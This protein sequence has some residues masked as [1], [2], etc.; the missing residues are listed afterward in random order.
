MLAAC[1]EGL[2]QSR[3]GVQGKGCVQFA[4]CGRVS[5]KPTASIGQWAYLAG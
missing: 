5:R 2:A 4:F 3:A 1:T